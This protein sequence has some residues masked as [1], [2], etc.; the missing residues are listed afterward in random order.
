[1]PIQYT[2]EQIAAMKAIKSRLDPDW[3]LGQGTFFPQ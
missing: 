3:R 1:L 2:A